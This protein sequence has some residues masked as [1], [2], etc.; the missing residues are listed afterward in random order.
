MTKQLLLLRFA[1]VAAG[2]IGLWGCTGEADI[3]VRYRE[4]GYVAPGPPVGFYEGDVYYLDF[5]TYWHHHH[6]WDR[7]RAWREWQRH[8]REPR[9]EERRE[10]RREHRPDIP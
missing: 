9:R 5:D 2:G 10:E 4:P 8:P 6:D 3:G 1:V 7:D